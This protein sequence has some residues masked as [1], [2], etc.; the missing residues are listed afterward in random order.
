MSN[1]QKEGQLIDLFEDFDELTDSNNNVN[2]HSSNSINKFTAR[3]IQDLSN[4][5]LSERSF[6]E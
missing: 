4:F 6:A 1:A 3:I 2:V 5:G